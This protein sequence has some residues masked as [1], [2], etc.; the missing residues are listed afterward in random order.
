MDVIIV[1]DEDL[2]REALRQMLLLLDPSLNIVG[3]AGTVE[4]G[5]Q[6]LKNTQVD[7]VFL[8]IN[9]PDGNGFNIL[10]NFLLQYM[11]MHTNLK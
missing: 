9:L 6:L 11:N 1:E 3:E 8:D 10:Q 4:E 7:L 2:S 5:T